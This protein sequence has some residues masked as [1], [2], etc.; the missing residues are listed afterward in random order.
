M[1]KNVLL[2]KVSYLFETSEDSDQEY[3]KTRK[4]HTISFNAN[5]FMCS[6]KIIMTQRNMLYLKKITYNNI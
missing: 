1:K 5:D 4:I 2:V 6:Y 3:R